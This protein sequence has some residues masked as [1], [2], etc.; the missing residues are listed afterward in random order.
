M[1]SF[2]NIPI[3][4]ILFPPF[5]GTIVLTGLIYLIGRQGSGKFLA[6]ASVGI[7][8]AWFCS[9]II[10]TP[11]FP[12][13]FN[14][15]GIISAAICLLTIGTILDFYLYKNI[16]LQRPTKYIPLVISGIVITIWMRNSVDFWSILHVLGWITIMFS[17]QHVSEKK[18]FG[19]RVSTLLLAL[20]SF[21]LGLIAWISDIAIEP[22]LTFGLSAI[23][24]GFLICNY[25]M[26]KL[27]FGSSILFAGAGSLYM[28]AMRVAEQALALV[29]AIILLGFILFIANTA[30]QS[31]TNL[32]IIRLL[33]N[34]IKIIILAIFPLMLSVL[35]TIIA[36][37][38]T[39]K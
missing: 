14:N 20:T 25:I 34:S 17:L 38:F 21:G 3:L 32:K 5:F 11:D 27:C 2:F 22:I 31:L 39:D 12:P 1:Y 29:P 19:S 10:G 35:A 7:S 36:T 15:S 4:N 16:K 8:F 26:P 6:N 13:E 28:L 33:P 37:E 9:F 24:F 18:Y 23:F 30:E